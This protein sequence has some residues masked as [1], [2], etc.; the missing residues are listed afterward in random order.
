MATETQVD[1]KEADILADGYQVLHSKSP[2]FYDHY[3]RKADLQHQTHYCPGCGHGIVHK[4]I[5]EALED[6]GLQDFFAPGDRS[7]YLLVE[8]KLTIDENVFPQFLSENGSH[9]SVIKIN[10]EVFYTRVEIGDL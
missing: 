10:I 1:V 6:L 9:Q 8:I 3:E 7:K 4:L 2:L 5:A